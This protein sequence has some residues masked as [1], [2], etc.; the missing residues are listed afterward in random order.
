MRIAFPPLAGKVRHYRVSRYIHYSAGTPHT[1]PDPAEFPFHSGRDAGPR[2]TYRSPA[3][4]RTSCLRVYGRQVRMSML[5]SYQAR[6]KIRLNVRRA[7]PDCTRRPLW[8]S[9]NTNFH[10]H[11]R[12]RSDIRGRFSEALTPVPTGRANPSRPPCSDPIL[13]PR[14]RCGAGRAFCRSAWPLPSAPTGAR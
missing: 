12:Y 6:V 3:G 4:K 14:P 8:W 11:L 10:C 1:A 13:I 7:G 9:N 2:G 5:K